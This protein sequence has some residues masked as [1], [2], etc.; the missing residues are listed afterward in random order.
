MKAFTDYTAEDLATE[1]LFIKWVQQPEDHEVS[2]FWNGWV[3]RNPAKSVEVEEARD[4]VTFVSSHYE[5]LNGRET[6][7][8][9]RRIQYSVGEISEIKPLEP[10]TKQWASSIYMGRWL[11]ALFMFCIFVSWLVLRS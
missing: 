2:N 7:S 4:I 8:L 3:H 1:P 10:N 6:R 11:F 9:W 5:N